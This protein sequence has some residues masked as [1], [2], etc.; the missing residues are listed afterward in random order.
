MVIRKSLA[1]K[2]VGERQRR[3]MFGNASVY[4][5]AKN[6]RPVGPK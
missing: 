3:T 5:T 6:Y 2:D 4:S 1:G